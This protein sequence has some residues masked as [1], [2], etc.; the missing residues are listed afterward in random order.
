MPGRT[1]Q[2]VQPFASALP[3]PSGLGQAQRVFDCLVSTGN[4][5]Y[6]AVCGILDCVEPQGFEALDV[7]SNF[8]HMSVFQCLDVDVTSCGTVCDMSGEAACL[9]WQLLLQNMSGTECCNTCRAQH[10]NF[11]GIRRQSQEVKPL[12]LSLHVVHAHIAKQSDAC[13]IGARMSITTS[14]S[15]L[16]NKG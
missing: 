8:K 9:G 16:S 1:L 4:P 12:A 3:V 7:G 10:K 14:H 2:A 6:Y 11:V 15:H 5:S 13:A